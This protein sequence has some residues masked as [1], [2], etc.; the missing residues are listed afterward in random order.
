MISRISLK[1]TYTCV[2]CDYQ[3][4]T[5]TCQPN[6]SNEME[7]TNYIVKYKYYTYKDHTK[8]N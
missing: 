7:L 4:Q 6:A 8:I 2:Q 5:Y 3:N 1:C